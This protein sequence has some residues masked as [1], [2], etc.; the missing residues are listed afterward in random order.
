MMAA[1]FP[2]LLSFLSRHGANARELQMATRAPLGSFY[3]DD[4]RAWLAAHAAATLNGSSG[5]AGV[6]F[7]AWGGCGAGQLGLSVGGYPVTVTPPADPKEVGR[8]VS[9]CVWKGAFFLRA[10]AGHA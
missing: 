6:A 5:C 2:F 9:L 3:G 4:L 10:R 1:T 8:S 7:A